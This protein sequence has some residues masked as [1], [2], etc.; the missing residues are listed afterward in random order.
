MGSAGVYR[1]ELLNAWPS[2]V[3]EVQYGHSQGSEIAKLPV[4][5]QYEKWIPK[6]S[7]QSAGV[8]VP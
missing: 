6:H 1:V 3:A 5:F 2:I 7:T 4:T 8:V